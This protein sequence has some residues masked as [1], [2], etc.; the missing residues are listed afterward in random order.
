MRKRFWITPASA[1][2]LFSAFTL[3]SLPSSAQYQDTYLNSAGSY[4]SSGNVTSSTGSQ[5][6]P[7]SFGTGSPTG[8]T[9]V[10]TPYNIARSGYDLPGAG[11]DILKPVSALGLPIASTT[12]QLAP[13][14]VN[15]NGF[16]SD[17][18][19]YGFL[20]KFPVTPYQAINGYTGLPTVSTSSVDL[21]SCNLPLTRTGGFFG[22]MEGFELE[23]G[24]T[25]GLGGLVG[26]GLSAAGVNTGIGASMMTGGT[27]MSAPL[28]SPGS[29][30]GNTGMP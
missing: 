3:A 7:L 28:S 26:A 14:S 9:T 8:S 25:P 11:T 5:V 20:N 24:S 22:A 30:F 10:Q 23:A 1:L 19:N 21:N 27:P 17:T 13:N 2:I 18:W 15:T 16:P 6:N 29:F 12:T 4:G